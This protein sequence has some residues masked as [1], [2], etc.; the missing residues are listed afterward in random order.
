MSVWLVLCLH[1]VSCLTSRM[2]IPLCGHWGPAQWYN[3]LATDSFTQKYSAPVFSVDNPMPILYGCTPKIA[4]QYM[5]DRETTVSNITTI[6]KYSPQG[7][8][9][10][11]A[12]NGNS[13]NYNYNATYLPLLPTNNYYLSTVT[14]K[15]SE[16]VTISVRYDVYG[17]IVT[18]ETDKVSSY[19]EL[20]S[21]ASLLVPSLSVGVADTHLIESVISY[22]KRII[23]SPLSVMNYHYTDMS[24]YPSKVDYSLL[25]ITQYYEDFV[26]NITNNLI[27]SINITITQPSTTTTEEKEKNNNI[28]EIE[29]SFN[30]FYQYFYDS[31]NSMMTYACLNGC[32]QS[33]VT[34]SYDTSGRL[35]NVNQ[36]NGMVQITYTGDQATSV[37]MNGIKWTLEY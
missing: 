22:R 19:S 18:L 27:S 24:G 15:S 11:W 8:V 28:D 33:K 10:F 9:T 4:V 1:I 37:L 12:Q 35:V 29:S 13:Y 21:F 7:L 14:I 20:S 5:N 32:D 31:T 36:L 25:G 17:R 2:S 3:N 23:Q 30:L 16:S 34:F 6:F 26:Y